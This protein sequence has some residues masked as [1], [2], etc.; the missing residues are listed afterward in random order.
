MRLR[1]VGA[2]QKGQWERDE[3]LLFGF[4]APWAGKSALQLEKSS[5][6]PANKYLDS[7]G[8]Q[9]FRRAFG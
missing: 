7:I 6:Q 2:G 3:E 8:S 9:I 5:R 1:L 4:I